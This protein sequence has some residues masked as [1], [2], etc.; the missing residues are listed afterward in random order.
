VVSGFAGGELKNH[1]F[2]YSVIIVDL[3]DLLDLLRKYCILG[4][5]KEIPNLCRKKLV[6][7]KTK[8]RDFL[9]SN[10]QSS[11]YNILTKHTGLINSLILFLMGAY[12]HLY[13]LK[14]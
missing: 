13:P 3:F 4:N 10:V 14:L 5:K 8:G 6:T 9:W 7:Q 11:F 1:K 2:E 12:I